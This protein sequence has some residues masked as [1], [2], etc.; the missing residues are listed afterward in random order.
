ML[1]LLGQDLA[2]VAQ[3]VLLAQVE[4]DVERAVDDRLVAALEGARDVGLGAAGDDEAEAGF[5]VEAVPGPCALVRVNA[6]VTEIQTLLRNRFRTYWR[7]SS[8]IFAMMSLRFSSGSLLASLSK[9]PMV[10]HCRS[11]NR[12]CHADNSFS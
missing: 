8:F 6:S 1:Q 4:E 11:G 9:N 2:L 10:P 5:R 7:G 3:P 12:A